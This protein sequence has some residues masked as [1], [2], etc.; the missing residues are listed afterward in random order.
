[1]SEEFLGLGSCQPGVE[2]MGGWMMVGCRG[3]TRGFDSE[4]AIEC[5]AIDETMRDRQSN[6]QLEE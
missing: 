5:S 4:Q 6:T 2:R 1:M 3:R